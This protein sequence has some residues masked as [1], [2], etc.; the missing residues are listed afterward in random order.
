MGRMK[1]RARHAA[2]FLILCAACGGNFVDRANQT[3]GTALAAT[4][5]AKEAFVEWDA[6][7][8]LRIVERAASRDEADTK[9]AAYRDAR[10]SVV[11]AFSI[12]YSSL[13]AAAAMIPLIESGVKKEIDVLGLIE[14]SVIAAVAVRDA[15]KEISDAFDKTPNDQPAGGAEAAAEG[16][17]T[18]PPEP[19]PAGLDPEPAP[20]P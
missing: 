10:G 20:G 16:A 11:A 1:P 19:P 5:A 12:A 3:L 18:P 15:V 9:L 4:N 14:Q 8:Q 6:Q 7:I 13:S 2:L 17:A